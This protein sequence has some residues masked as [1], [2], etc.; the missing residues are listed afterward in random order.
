MEV[1]LIIMIV[2]VEEEAQE[3]ARFRIE[4]KRKMFKRLMDNCGC[5]M[6]TEIR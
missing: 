6:T 4:G 3:V 2:A 1:V 5:L